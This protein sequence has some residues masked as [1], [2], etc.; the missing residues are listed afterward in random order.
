VAE[1]AFQPELQAAVAMSNYEQK[2]ATK[3][4]ILLRIAVITRKIRGIRPGA[5]QNLLARIGLIAKLIGILARYRI[6]FRTFEA[7]KSCD[8]RVIKRG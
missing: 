8:K 3:R 4:G 7:S 1:A 6:A 5:R 2:I